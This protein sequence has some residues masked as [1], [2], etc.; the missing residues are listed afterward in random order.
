M[1][2]QA[3]SLFPTMTAAENV[4]FG[5]WMRKTT[6]PACSGSNRP[7]PVVCPVNAARF[8]CRRTPAD[9][10]SDS[11]GAESRLSQPP[12]PVGGRYRPWT[13]VVST[14]LGIKSFRMGR[15]AIPRRR[16]LC[17]VACRPL[18]SVSSQSAI[19]RLR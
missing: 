2:F 3:Y 1:V 16:P 12:A 15:P 4:A 18:A 11:S 17:K 6:T 8:R 14:Q 13:L 5:L 10:M 7:P 9:D 19:A